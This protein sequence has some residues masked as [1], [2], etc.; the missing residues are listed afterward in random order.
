MIAMNLSK[1]R[2]SRRS[3][4]TLAAVVGTTSL[5]IGAHAALNKRALDVAR[6]RIPR[7]RPHALRW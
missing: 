2:L 7:K 4:A 5:A 6:A 3:I 1:L